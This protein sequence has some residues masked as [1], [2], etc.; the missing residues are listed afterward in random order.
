MSS[1]NFNLS[2]EVAAKLNNNTALKAGV[3][4]LAEEVQQL[5][6]TRLEQLIAGM[7]AKATASAVSTSS[8]TGTA[9]TDTGTASKAAATS[10]TPNST[11]NNALALAST[12][13]F[14]AAGQTNA[15]PA[16]TGTAATGNWQAPWM[17][18]S[19]D[20]KKY[21][22][23]SY[24]ESEAQFDNKPNLKQFM[25][26]TGSDFNTASN[27]LYGVVGSN[28]EMRNWDAIMK[29]ADPLTA[30][31]QATGAMYSANNPAIEA[32]PEHQLNPLGVKAR[33]EN[34]AWEKDGQYERLF[35]NRL[36][37]QQADPS[38]ADR[39]GHFGEN[40]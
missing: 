8:S 26:A 34:L 3:N 6:A 19:A 23:S 14:L 11:D 33:T 5:F 10:T 39:T 4:K 32:R 16:A 27:L 20:A 40:A 36:C 17:V 30:A 21:L 35:F 28:K 38:A 1:F 24:A 22:H 9:S 37:R 13:S 15:A 2:S 31:R 29:S 18:G 12:S 7:D 25:D